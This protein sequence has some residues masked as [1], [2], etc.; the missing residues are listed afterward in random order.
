MA[1][2]TDGVDGA[3][4]LYKQLWHACAG[5]LVT[6]PRQG[7]L[8]FYFPQGHI[9]QVEASTNQVSDRQMPAYDLPAKI[10]CRV[11][12]VRLKAEPA[13]DEVFA[14]QDENNVA[15]DTTR[16]LPLPSRSRVFSFCKT[17]TASDTSTHGGFSV[18]RRHAEECLP[19]LD[20]SGQPPAQD[21][22]AQDLHGNEWRFR[23]IYRGQ[24]RR[25]L[26]QSGWSLF[27]SSKKLVAGDAFIF[28]RGDNGE[29][30]VGVRRALRQQINVPTSVISCHS[31]H[32]GILASA[33]H[34]ISTGTMFTVYY[35]PRT[36]PAEFIIPFDKYME[37]LK[38][39]HSVGMRFKMRFEGEE[40]PEQRFSGTVT[41]V[42]DADHLRWPGSRWRCLKVR[43]DETYPI[44]RP[45]R[46]SPWTLEPAMTPLDPVPACRLRW[47]HPKLVLPSADSSV[48]LREGSS[49]VTLDPSPHDGFTEALENRES[50]ALR[51]L[52]NANNGS[53][54]IGWIPLQ[55]DKQTISDCGKRKCGGEDKVHEVMHMKPLSGPQS[56]HGIYKNSRA[57]VEHNHDNIDHL[58]KRAFDREEIFK[59][60]MHL[61]S[62][63]FLNPSFR[64]CEF[65]AELPEAEDKLRGVEAVHQPGSQFLSLFPPHPMALGSSPHLQKQEVGTSRRDGN[66]RLF[67]ISLSSNSPETELA[68]L[69]NNPEQQVQKQHTP[70]SDQL[71]HLRSYQRLEQLE[72]TT[73]GCEELG[74]SLQAPNQVSKDVVGK[75]Q[76]NSYRSCIKVHKQGVALGRSVDLTKFSGYDELVAEFDKIFE[77]GGEL[78]AADKKWLIV[79][80]DDEGDMML[81]GDDPWQEFCCMVRKIFIYTKEEVNRMGGQPSPRAEQNSPTANHWSRSQ[82]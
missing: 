64:M 65:S 61:Q 51:G 69:C 22:V 9:E 13:T 19:Q 41:G 30:R 73:I 46:V 82:E 33:W 21:L 59:M 1:A 49:K 62:M 53:N 20:M 8:V 17:L 16:L 43:W 3:G 44:Y 72:C 5:P 74:S 14:Q 68:M 77:F 7:E 57:S 76:G 18:L 42:E 48:Y 63:T 4:D 32:I 75:L 39:D 70:A 52:S 78:I 29:L 6:V 15:K 67:G 80:T 36:S 66:C 34:A 38:S 47:P 11:V 10:L 28:L 58:R 54:S 45:E 24:P 25:H 55:G 35:K 12:N 2:V 50:L 81:V 27:I 60:P 31:M 79:F 37:S 71:Q 23:H 26:L 40:A 56:P